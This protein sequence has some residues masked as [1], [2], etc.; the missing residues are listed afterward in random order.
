[1][2]FLIINNTMAVLGETIE[3]AIVD[4]TETDGKLPDELADVFTLT[5]AS[6]VNPDG[7]PRWILDWA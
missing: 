3:K 6:V 1:M 7:S 5:K 2:N 4:A